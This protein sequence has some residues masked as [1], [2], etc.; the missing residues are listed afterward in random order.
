M[1]WATAPRQGST[2]S[3]SD[4]V[5][6]FDVPA[7]C[8][9]TLKITKSAS[10]SPATAGQSL[11]YSLL[12]EN[13]T[14]STL[15]NVTITDNVPAGTT[16]AGPATCSGSQAGGVVTFTLGNMA[17]GASQTCSFNVTV[18]TGLGTV[19]FFSDDMESGSSAWSATAGSG[20]IQ[21]EPGHGQRRTARPTPGSHRTWRRCR[22]SC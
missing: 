20:L 8:Q 6:A 10:P 11:T 15:T 22:S 18:N 14:T 13:Q 2:G 7:S 9:Q 17:A 12:V 16:Y 4:G 19:T 1:A 5:Q 21:L 3:R